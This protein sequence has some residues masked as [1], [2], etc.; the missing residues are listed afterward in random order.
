MYHEFRA[1][2]FNIL[3]K[4]KEAQDECK[5]LIGRSLTNLKNI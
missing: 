4:K 2:A 1:R 3:G 5:I